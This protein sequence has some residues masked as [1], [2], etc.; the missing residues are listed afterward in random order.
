VNI[1][2]DRVKGLLSTHEEGVRKLASVRV[3]F[4]LHAGIE[5]PVQLLQ[6]KEVARHDDLVTIFGPRPNQRPDAIDV[7]IVLPVSVCLPPFSLRHFR[8]CA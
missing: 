5:T 3:L 2:Y 7:R 4:Y 6:E 8:F 1:A